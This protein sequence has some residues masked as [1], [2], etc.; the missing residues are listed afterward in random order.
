MKA[1]THSPL[2]WLVGGIVSL[3]LAN[4]IKNPT[5]LNVTLLDGH[6]YGSPEDIL[7]QGSRT[8]LL[9]LGM[10]LVIA[11]GGVDLSVGSIVAIAGATCAVLLRDG[12]GLIATVAAALESGCWPVRSTALLSRDWAFSR[13][14]RL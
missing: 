1:R 13:S 3:V 12:H 10:T 6:L 9:A 8:M 11:I 5:F 4:L 7:T 14:S 2:I